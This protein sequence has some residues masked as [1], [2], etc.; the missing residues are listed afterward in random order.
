MALDDLQFSY[1]GLTFGAGTDVFVDE[2][3]GFYG[4]DTRM[5]DSDLPRGDGS[6]RGL[7]YVNARTMAFTL[8]LAG[9]VETDYEALWATVRAAFT[10]SRTDDTQLVIKRPG[11]PEQVVFCR[12][13]QLVRKEKYLNFD[14]VGNPTIVMRAADPRIY[15][16]VEHEQA[17]SV[18][19]PNPA[20][21]DMPIVEFPADFTGGAQNE[22]VVNN[23]GTANAYPLIRFFGPKTG[24]CT[25]VTLTNTMSGDSLS[26]ATTVTTGQILT[27]DMQAAVTGANRLVVSLDGTSRYGSWAVPR[28]ALP[29]E[30]GDNT[31]R[32]QVTG[33]STDMICIIS[34]RD[35][36]LG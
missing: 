14:Q 24:T 3:D 31:F 36:W 26:I 29:I 21:L 17:A 7:D 1:G 11:Q 16:S 22:L 32:F 5:S 13:I 19:A 8:A 12:P 34:Y 23:A 25:G 15:S 4:Y 6:I 18:Y 2:A 10:P 33:T 28:A 20:G 27:A 9:T 30:P 35:T